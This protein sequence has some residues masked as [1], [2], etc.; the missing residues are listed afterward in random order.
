M[1]RLSGD[2]FPG[3]TW[4]CDEHYDRKDG[5]EIA[6]KSRFK[7]IPVDFAG[8]RILRFISPIIRF[9]S[10]CAPKQEPK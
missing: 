5:F 8:L 10:D 2:Q 1:N 6:Q 7:Q 3:R 4:T 9:W